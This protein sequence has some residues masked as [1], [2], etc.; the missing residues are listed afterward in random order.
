[1]YPVDALPDADE[2][3]VLLYGSP[4]VENER[5]GLV[6]DMD[7]NKASWLDDRYY[8]PPENTENVWAPLDVIL[9][10]W[11]GVI[12]RQRHLPGGPETG[13]PGEVE[14]WHFSYPPP[15]DLEDALVAWDRYIQ[16]VEG[17]LPAVQEIA[18]SQES[19]SSQHT[20]L[21][22]MAASFLHAARKPNF[23]FIAPELVFPDE[24]QM[25]QL[26]ERQRG[27]F[28]AANNGSIEDED[29]RWKNVITSVL[30]PLGD[31]IHAALCLDDNRA[32]Q[33]AAGLILPS[34]ESYAR[35]SGEI[36]IHNT[37]APD[38][39]RV[40]QST[41]NFSPFWER[42]NMRLAS[43][44]NL[45]AR[46]VEEGTWKVN[47]TGIAGALRDHLYEE[48]YT[49]IAG[50]VRIRLAGMLIDDVEA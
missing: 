46:F 13:F 32:W 17:R 28:L 44:F 5:I 1:M 27:R 20:G 11:L 38:F 39:E 21:R 14:G 3:L 24:T 37:D 9:E 31:D 8:A 4:D 48:E 40:W 15:Q 41:S 34:S 19:S 18:A 43:I 12:T 36:D 50:D 10:A 22:G 26:A 23:K 25:T 35:F 33:D 7:S 16:L 45:W 29:E 30:F 49:D 2:N 6:F 42:H 47:G